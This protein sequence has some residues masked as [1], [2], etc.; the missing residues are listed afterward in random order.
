MNR[1]TVTEAVQRLV[2]ESDDVHIDRASLDQL[3]A[4]L[5]PN[6]DVRLGVVELA[7]ELLGV[8]DLYAVSA[9]GWSVDLSRAA[10]Q[11]AIATA[12]VITATRTSGMD[13]LP[14]LVLALV[15]PFVV[16]LQRVEVRTDDSLVLAAL[17]ANLTTRDQID[18]VYRQLPS[19]VSDQ[20]NLLEFAAIVD[21]LVSHGLLERDPLG[22]I[23]LPDAPYGVLALR[24]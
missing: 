24:C 19:D 20:V 21:R 11:T 5:V 10:L 3:A 6:P 12:I 23:E 17:A 9:G 14:V 7:V 18:G 15:L 22:M 16:D 4:E 2:G 13:S 1:A 8:Q